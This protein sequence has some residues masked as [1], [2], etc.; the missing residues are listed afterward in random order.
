[1]IDWATLDITDAVE[2]VTGF[3]GSPAFLLILGAVAGFV[4]VK[5]LFSY[6]RKIR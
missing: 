4:G 1:M 5:V 2:A 3:I 6:L